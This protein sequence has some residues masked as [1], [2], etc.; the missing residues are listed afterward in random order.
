[1]QIEI[2]SKLIWIPDTNNNSP[3]FR[4]PL[5]NCFNLDMVLS[6]SLEPI[7][8][9]F[10]LFL[11]STFSLAKTPIKKL[12]TFYD[13]FFWFTLGED[14]LLLAFARPLAMLLFH[15]LKI[16]NGVFFV[17]GLDWNQIPWEPQ[18]RAD[19]L[20][21]WFQISWPLITPDLLLVD[22]IFHRHLI[23]GE[24]LVSSQSGGSMSDKPIIDQECGLLKGI[25]FEIEI[26]Y[27]EIF[28]MGGI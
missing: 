18:S 10:L 5:K 23:G 19:I 11:L 12:L 24:S 17:C 8:P 3:V 6:F 20:I 7:F 9:R 2:E 1:M 15:L 28:W 27:S 16:T 25:V 21:G 13:N 22:W 26:R 4:E 14:A